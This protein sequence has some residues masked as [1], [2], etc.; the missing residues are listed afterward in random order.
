MP[1]IKEVLESAKSG[2]P[3]RITH[4]GRLRMS[5][6]EF[7]ERINVRLRKL[8]TARD[9]LLQQK[10]VELTTFAK[11][12]SRS[13]L[14]IAP[15]LEIGGKTVKVWTQKAAPEVNQGAFVFVPIFEHKIRCVFDL[16]TAEPR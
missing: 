9:A 4:A 10:G 11:N 3:G 8:R 2:L 16:K 13:V 6:I 1:V 14:S 15:G 12:G 7:E 5:E